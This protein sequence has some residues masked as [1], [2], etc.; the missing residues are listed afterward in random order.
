MFRPRVLFALVLCAF[1][2]IMPFPR[3]WHWPPPA[4][5]NARFRTNSVPRRPNGKAPPG[6]QKGASFYELISKRQAS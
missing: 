5:T 2:A 3:K 4:R 1:A 6:R